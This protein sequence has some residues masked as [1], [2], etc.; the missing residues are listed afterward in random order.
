MT[1]LIINFQNLVNNFSAGGLDFDGVAGFLALERFT[2]GGLHAD[3]TLERVDFLV[4]DDAVN[5]FAFGL[6]VNHFDGGAKAD[7]TVLG[8]GIFNN[9]CAIQNAVEFTQAAV[10]FAHAHTPVCVGG[11]FT[12]VAFG[13]GGLHLVDHCR[14]FDIFEMFPFCLEFF[15]AFFRNQV[16]HAVKIKKFAVYGL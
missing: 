1:C 4:A 11:V 8:G 13:S 3:A 6:L 2:D 9:L 10:D 12:A 16:F 14:A 15:K 7:G 5:F